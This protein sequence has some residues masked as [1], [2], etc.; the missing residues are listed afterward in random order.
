MVSVP[1][2]PTCHNPF[3]RGDHTERKK[4]IGQT[5]AAAKL[6]GPISLLSD[7]TGVAVSHNDPRR[8]RGPGRVD[9][10]QGRGLQRHRLRPLSGL[11]WL[12]FNSRNILQSH[13]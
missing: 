6:P 13:C 8:H 2:T 7:D 11:S 1:L 5:R 12:M 10:A 4:E 3:L 9:V